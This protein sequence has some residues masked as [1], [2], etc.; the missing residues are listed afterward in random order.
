MMVPDV[1]MRSDADARAQ[2][3]LARAQAP[4]LARLWKAALGTS[5]ST[6]QGDPLTFS[7][8]PVV[9][10]P[11]VV[12]AP[13]TNAVAP[14][15]ARSDFV[16]G[17]FAGL[18]S[19]AARRTG[20]PPAALATVIEA[21]AGKR[22]DGSW[23]SGSRNSR[24]SAAGLGQFLSRTWIGEA[25]RRG[26]ALNA[27]AAANGWLDAKG[28]VKAAAQPALLQLRFDPATAIEAVADFAHAGL[29]RL[30]AAGITVGRDPARVATLA[31][32]GHHLGAAEA[33]RFLGGQLAPA[34]AKLLLTAQV[35]EGEAVRRIAAA[36]GDAVAAHRT[37][38]QGYIGRVT[39][40]MLGH[41][42]DHP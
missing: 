42:S 10:M 5:D 28:R 7:L 25:E 36:A 8:P 6:G 39:G 11:G 9:R 41:R 32:V 15:M 30:K 34:R 37:W 20:I 21:E 2:I 23:D 24:S 29:N 35:G 12:P 26:T 4:L 31:W 40:R 18:I 13:T 1:S 14:P 33:V 38:L 17:N 3:L 22:R 19:S 16:G 27:T